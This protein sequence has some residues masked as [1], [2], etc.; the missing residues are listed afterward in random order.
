MSVGMIDGPVKIKIT[1]EMNILYALHYF[2]NQIHT[3]LSTVLLHHFGGSKID[4]GSGSICEDPPHFLY[5][6]H[7][8]SLLDHSLHQ[9]G[10][11]VE[12]QYLRMGMYTEC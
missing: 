9:S 3:D 12:P 7:L 4:G 11:H 2:S 10:H 6:V 5:T 8:G 1:K